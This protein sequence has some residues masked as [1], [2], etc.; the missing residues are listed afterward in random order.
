LRNLFRK[1][2]PIILHG[3]AGRRN[4]KP[5]RHRPTR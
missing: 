3:V 2:E 5:H 1:V 4:R